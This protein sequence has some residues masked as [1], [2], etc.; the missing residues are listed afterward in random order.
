MNVATLARFASKSQLKRKN[1]LEL[2][3]LCLELQITITD[4]ASKDQLINALLEAR[5]VEIVGHQYD[6]LSGVRACSALLICMPYSAPGVP[7][8]QTV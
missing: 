1:K 6:K 2:E 8:L 5:T 7:V 3:T 4:Q